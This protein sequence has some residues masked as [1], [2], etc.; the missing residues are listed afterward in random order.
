MS[1]FAGLGD[2]KS[3]R[4]IVVKGILF[5]G[6][7]VGTTALI[8]LEAPSIRLAALLAILVWSSCR[9]YYF[10]FYVLE[11]YVNPNLRYAGL[12]GLLTAIRRTRGRKG[13]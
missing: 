11:K 12:W 8:L 4:I 3:K 7:V 6:I 9:L 13:A 2:L 10:L 5:L 1:H